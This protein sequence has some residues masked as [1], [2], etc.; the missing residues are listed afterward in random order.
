MRNI[1]LIGGACHGQTWPVDDALRHGDIVRVRQKE[2]V[3]ISFE[4]YDAS[5]VSAVSSYEYRINDFH[6]HDGANKTTTTVAIPAGV[7]G[8]PFEFVIEIAFTH[9]VREALGRG[10]LTP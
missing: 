1:R 2:H 5:A 8:N 9:Q 7:H 10:D 3:P 4:V 6:W